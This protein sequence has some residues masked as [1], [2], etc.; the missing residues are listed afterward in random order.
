MAFRRGRGHDGAGRRRP[1]VSRGC[2]SVA[3]S[4]LA[5]GRPP[6]LRRSRCRCRGR[7][8]GGARVGGRRARVAGAFP[9]RSA[10]AAR[11]P[12]GSARRAAGAIA[13]DLAADI[14][15]PVTEAEAEVRRAGELLRAD[16][17]PP[18]EP[19][20]RVSAETLWRRAP[21]GVVAI[22]TPWNN[23]VGIPL[24]KIGPA[25]SLG[26]SVL[27]KPAPAAS[28]LT[29]A[30]L[31]MAREAGVP[32]GLIRVVLGDHAT[33]RALMEDERVDAVSLSGSSAAGWTA[34]EICARRRIPL[35]AE[36]GGNNASIVWEGADLSAAAASV[37]RGAFGFAGQ[38]CTANRRAVVQDVLFDGFLESVAAATADLRWGDPFDTST[39]V[40]PLVSA[41]ARDRV[42]AAVE[43]S[44]G[45]AERV[46]VPHAGPAPGGD[47]A[48][49]PPTIVVGA[50]PWSEIVQT[51]TFGPV[52]VLQRA[53]DFEEA[54]ALSGGVRQGLV[55]A[56]FGGEAQAGRF[57][58]GRAP[59]C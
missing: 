1:A 17:S 13:R 49:L 4:P 8:R 36:L 18:E 2:G 14:G 28:R 12:G 59:A 37:A 26:N 41:A 56:L 23:P 34:Q 9:G 44:R 48:Y 3:D 45:E 29:L 5:P 24:G 6:A 57:S 39:D 47:G 25:L 46:V 55:S 58:I 38:R 40:G 10:P 31:D 50:A 42:A 19:W 54:L 20:R 32:E 53:R 35:Q 52:L 11:T 33:A 51:E 21:V 15:K 7:G 43:R 27:W 16:P 22:V 30:I